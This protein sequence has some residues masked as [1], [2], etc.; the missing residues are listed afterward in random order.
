VFSIFLKNEVSG[1]W[2]KKV[3]LFAPLEGATNVFV[4]ESGCVE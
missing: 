1:L 3:V 2:L 4:F